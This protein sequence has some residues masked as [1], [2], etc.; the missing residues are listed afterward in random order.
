MLSFIGFQQ[1]GKTTTAKAMSEF[2]NCSWIDTDK[3][4]ESRFQMPIKVLYTQ[5][6][7]EAFRDVESQVILA[8]DDNE[9]IIS[10]GGG[11]VLREENMLHL[12]RLG[13]IVFL[14]ISFET[15]V[16]RQQ[17]APL[18]LANQRIEDVFEKRLRFYQ[19]YADIIIDCEK[20]GGSHE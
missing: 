4:L 9:A 7:E 18:F 14:N 15:Y 17:A 13:R 19:K 20:D 16:K 5:L 2:L 6:G 8:I 10:T 11:A 12:K 1:S 3:L